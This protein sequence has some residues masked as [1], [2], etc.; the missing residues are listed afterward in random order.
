MMMTPFVFSDFLR[1]SGN[2]S[3]VPSGMVKVYQHIKKISSCFTSRSCV[4]TRFAH[5]PIRHKD[6]F[7]QGIK[8]PE[9]FHGGPAGGNRSLFR[10]L[11]LV[12]W[13]DER[14]H[15]HLPA[16]LIAG[17]IMQQTVVP[18]MIRSAVLI[19]IDLGPNL[20][21][22]GSLATILWIMVL[23]KEGICISGWDFFKTGVWV[24]TV[25][26]LLSLLAV[27]LCHS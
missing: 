22:T 13:L 4:C 11:S 27:I 20:S 18:E 9:F 12:V 21:V 26:L 7:N 14:A 10:N 8:Q 15:R 16:G 24:M 19:G 25:P 3:S 1:Y 6:F 17:N 5:A 23:R 2:R